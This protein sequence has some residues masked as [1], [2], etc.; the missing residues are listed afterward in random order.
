MWQLALAI[1]LAGAACNGVLSIMGIHHMM[2]PGS[3]A[4]KWWDEVILQ[5]PM[6]NFL[7]AGQAA[8]ELAGDAE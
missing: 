6:C 5:F 8:G 2:S 1:Q 3:A 7:V 4:E